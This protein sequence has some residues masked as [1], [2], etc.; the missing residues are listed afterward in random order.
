MGRVSEPPAPRRTWLAAERTF[1]AWWRTGLAA[2]VAALGVGRLLPE[3]IEGATWPFVLLG[4]GYGGVAFGI[5]AAGAHRQRQIE[6]G[7]KAEE[8]RPLG[9]GIVDLL[10][11]AGAL[12][13][14]ATMVLIAVGA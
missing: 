4:L 14:I 8:F 6:S 13:T 2:S 11:L 5:F 1:L 7:L 3:V 9:R 10:S 12:L